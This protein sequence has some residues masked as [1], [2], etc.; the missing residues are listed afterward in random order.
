[1]NLTFTYPLF[2]R[3]VYKTGIIVITALGLFFVI[4]IALS[5]KGEFM[6]LYLT[7]LISVGLLIAN[8]S[9]YKIYKH[10][11]FKIVAEDDKIICNN[12]FFQKKEIEISYD[13]IEK[14]DGGVFTGRLYGLVKVYK[15]D[16]VLAFNYFYKL[17]NVKDFETIILSKMRKEIY[18]KVIGELSDT[19]SK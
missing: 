7:I 8:I 16:E 1:M 11:P 5:Y 2:N 17:N 6:N 10:M 4:P 18:E 19:K 9:F 14:I 3:I 12:Y 13:E 15:K